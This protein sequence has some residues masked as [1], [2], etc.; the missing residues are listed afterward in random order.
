MGQKRKPAKGYSSESLRML[1]SKEGQLNAIYALY[2]SAA[3]Q[4]QLLEKALSDLM[5]KLREISGHSVSPT[6]LRATESS[7]HKKTIG[8]LLKDFEN[9]T[10]NL[11][12]WVEDSFREARDKRN[13]LI[14][15]YFLERENKFQTRSN[16]M[17][18]LKELVL[19]QETLKRATDFA[20]GMRVAVS[21]ILDGV[22][23]EPDKI[24]VLFSFEIDVPDLQYENEQCS[25]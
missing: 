11:D 13:F 25:K 14:H 4:G 10:R 1:K 3:Q 5:I 15:H 22:R 6:N 20:N 18:V 23:K 16:R 7:S 12:K 2:G 19:I 9:N 8:Q 24:S 17:K 21:E